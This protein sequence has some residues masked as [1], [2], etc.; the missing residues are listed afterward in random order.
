MSDPPVR[1]WRKAPPMPGQPEPVSPLEWT[2]QRLLRM[3][4]PPVEPLPVESLP[5]RVRIEELLAKYPEGLKVPQFSALLDVS[6]FSAHRCADEAVLDGR[7]EWIG[8]DGQPWTGGRVKG[9]RVLRG[10]VK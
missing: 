1:I 2:V 4:K 8:E 7:A 5:R 3:A 6:I 10:V 9:G